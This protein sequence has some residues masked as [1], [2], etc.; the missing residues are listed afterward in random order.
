MQMSIEIIIIIIKMINKIKMVKQQQKQFNK[1]KLLKKKEKKL[2]HLFL[3]NWKIIFNELI[4]AIL[5]F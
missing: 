2:L 1:W 5:F 3:S 4:F